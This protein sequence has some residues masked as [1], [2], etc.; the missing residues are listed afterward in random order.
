MMEKVEEKLE[1]EE[2]LESE[3][4][5]TERG[6]TSH[7]GEGGGVCRMKAR[8][9]NQRTRGKEACGWPSLTQTY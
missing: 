3:G 8:G 6:R 7:M 4:A 1:A 9:E 5:V 2:L